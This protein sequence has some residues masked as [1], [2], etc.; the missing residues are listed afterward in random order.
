MII[1]NKKTINFSLRLV[2]ILLIVDVIALCIA[3][4][5]TSFTVAVICLFAIIFIFLSYVFIKLNIYVYES[6]GEVLSLKQYHPFLNQLS[7]QSYDI[8]AE[9]LGGYEISKIGVFYILTLK[10][11]ISAKKKIKRDFILLDLNNQNLKKMSS[12]LNNMNIWNTV[13][14]E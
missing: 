9:N 5:M 1:T 11:K 14:Q 8:P 7:A 6:S 2:I 4:T 10:I 12:S 3:V 13:T